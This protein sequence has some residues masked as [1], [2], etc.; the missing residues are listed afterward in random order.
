MLLA[1]LGT[2]P[3]LIQAIGHWTFDVFKAYIRTHLTL[4]QALLFSRR[5]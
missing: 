3:H 4:I 5:V 2:P 1:E